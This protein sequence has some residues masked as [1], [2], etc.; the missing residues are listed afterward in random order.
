MGD[1]EGREERKKKINESKVEAERNSKGK[2]KE[3]NNNEEKQRLLVSSV[4]GGRGY[5]NSYIHIGPN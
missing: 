1:L 5:T 4:V 3:Q 2:G